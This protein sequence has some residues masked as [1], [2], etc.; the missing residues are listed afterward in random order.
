MATVTKNA[1]ELGFK[2][3]T[4]AEL[5]HADFFSLNGKSFFIFS[6]VEEIGLGLVS[7]H[8]L[9]TVKWQSYDRVIRNDKKVFVAPFGRHYEG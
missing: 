3:I 6:K 4:I 5:E 1:K 8:Y 9:S 2:Q 7:I